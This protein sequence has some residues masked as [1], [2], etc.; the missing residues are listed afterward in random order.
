MHVTTW[1]RPWRSPV[2][3]WRVD[4]FTP[5]H[6]QGDSVKPG[7]LSA[8]PW[9]RFRLRI[10]ARD[11]R[12]CQRCGTARKLE[13]HHIVPRHRAPD[14]IYS[15]GNCTTICRDCHIR[16]HPPVL[17]PDAQAWR[18]YQLENQIT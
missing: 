12:R 6:V 15:E 8:R 5:I 7:K 2:A 3:L 14:K 16:E 10:L 11:K 4:R 17:A 9:S 18:T 1:P 13:V